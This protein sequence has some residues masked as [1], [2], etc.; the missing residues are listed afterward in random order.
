MRL[1]HE[2]VWDHA[3][4]WTSIISHWPLSNPSMIIICGRKDIFGFENFEAQLDISSL[5]V[6]KIFAWQTL[7]QPLCLSNN[8]ADVNPVRSPIILS[9]LYETLYIFENLVIRCQKPARCKN[10]SDR[11]QSQL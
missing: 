1:Q 9:N 5:I 7:S 6:C 2:R 10:T 8:P 3:K 4:F 11:Q